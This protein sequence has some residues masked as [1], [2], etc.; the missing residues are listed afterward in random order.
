[1]CAGFHES[2]AL[3]ACQGRGVCQNITLPAAAS[4][5]SECSNKLTCSVAVCVMPRSAHPLLAAAAS[6][7]LGTFCTYQYSTAGARCSRAGSVLGCRLTSVP[8]ADEVHGWHAMYERQ[9]LVCFAMFLWCHTLSSTTATAHKAPRVFSPA[10]PEGQSTPSPARCSTDT[11]T[12]NAQGS[13][14]A[15]QEVGQC[16]EQGATHFAQ[17]FGGD[18][19]HSNNHTMNGPNL[20]RS[21]AK[22]PRRRSR[23]ALAESRSCSWTGGS[24][25]TG[26][27]ATLGGSCGPQSLLSGMSLTAYCSAICWDELQGWD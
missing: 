7:V 6:G 17:V 21:R 14:M 4:R 13:T 23:G 3:L 2:S 24:V 11:T 20:S 1:M 25:A 22:T 27:H 8:V 5:L 9:K 15:G 10:G 26:V 16:S 12:G 19:W 18:S